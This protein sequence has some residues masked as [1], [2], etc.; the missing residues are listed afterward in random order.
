MVKNIAIMSIKKKKNY[1]ILSNFFNVEDPWGGGKLKFL[2]E[3]T[4]K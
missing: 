2:I 3:A 4:E 1:K